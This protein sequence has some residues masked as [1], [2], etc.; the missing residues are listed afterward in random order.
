MISPICKFRKELKLTLEL[1]AAEL[2]LTTM[3]YRLIEDGAMPELL[4]T[5]S[6]LADAQFGPGEGAKMEIEY[7]EFRASLSPA[8]VKELEG[9]LWPAG[10]ACGML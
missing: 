8:T 5:I 6:R 9:T 10:K 3:R 2:T 1:M 7:R 4:P